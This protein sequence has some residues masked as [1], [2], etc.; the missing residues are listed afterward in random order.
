MASKRKS[1]LSND[2]KRI[3]ML[4]LGLTCSTLVLTFSVLTLL[5]VQKET[6]E[7]APKYL[8][9]VFVF[10]GLTRLVTF[11]QDRSKYNL[12]RCL[13]LLGFDIALGIIVIF[14]NSNIYLFST[15]A[16]LYCLTIIISRIFKTIQRHTV[17]DIVFNV[18]IIVFAVL[19]CCG[20]FIPVDPSNVSSVILLECV[21]IAVTSLVEVASVT[22]AQL[23]FKVLFKII[24][25]TYSLEILFGLLALMVAFSLIFMAIEPG[26]PSF[27]DA[28]WFSF[29]VVTTI[30][31]GDMVATTLL[32]R[33][34]TV[35]LGM[36][37]IIAVA[38]ITSIIVNF[39]NET[40]GA[41]EDKKQIKDIQKEE[42]NK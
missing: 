31:F 6:Y 19:L 4:V 15:S 41:K 21:F 7:A 9:W 30:G 16:G 20:F 18:L 29:T 17:R 39:Y 2:M 28:L 34:L 12:I 3:I 22:L 5:A 8:V 26:M 37:G 36:Y 33:I 27:G 13:V 38:V 32:G 25:R 23:K 24:L 11:I 1:F 40:A 42:E 14:A 35:I 10:M